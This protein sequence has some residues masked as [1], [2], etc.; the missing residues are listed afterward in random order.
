MKG[1]WQ[2]ANE[3]EIDEIDCGAHKVS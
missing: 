2:K 3:K 1:W